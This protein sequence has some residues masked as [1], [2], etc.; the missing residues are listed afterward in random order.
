MKNKLYIVILAIILTACTPATIKVYRLIIPNDSLETTLKQLC[1]EVQKKKFI[2]EYE[3][4]PGE[5]WHTSEDYYPWSYE[6]SFY[7]EMNKDL[8]VYFRFN[9]REGYIEVIITELMVKEFS[10]DTIPIIGELEEL[11]REHNFT[12]LE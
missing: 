7:Y 11:L 5:C 9:E 3:I 6:S 1:V 10:K 2:R 4:S 12:K 8:S